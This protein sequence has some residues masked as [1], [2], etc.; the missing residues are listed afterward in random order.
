MN[1][2]NR[3]S[4][5][6]D[7]LVEQGLSQG[8]ILSYI[9]NNYLSGSEALQALQSVKKEHLDEDEEEE[10]EENWRESE[11]FFDEEEEGYNSGLLY[12]V[13]NNQ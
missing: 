8:D 2:R 12:G 1:S 13:D 7:F 6:L 9:L 10:K 5:L 11:D 4:E 3:A